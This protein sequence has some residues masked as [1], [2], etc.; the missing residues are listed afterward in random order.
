MLF[1]Y[2]KIFDIHLCYVIYMY[3]IYDTTL[4]IQKEKYFGRCSF[5]LA[6]SQRP[7]L[8]ILVPSGTGFS[9]PE[10]P[11]PLDCNLKAFRW[12]SQQ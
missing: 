3:H 11:C 8:G 12:T 7:C 1:V 10:Y 6:Q 5:V 2:V 9:G 4:M